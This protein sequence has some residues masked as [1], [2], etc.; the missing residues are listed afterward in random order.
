MTRKEAREA[1]Q[2]FGRKF[3]NMPPHRIDLR[4]SVLKRK[5]IPN[6]L[7]QE[8]REG[9]WEGKYAAQEEAK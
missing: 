3:E 2:Q 9:F 4:G 5:N 8:F 1:G 6:K 7:H